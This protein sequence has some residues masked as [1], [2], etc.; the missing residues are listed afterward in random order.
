MPQLCFPHPLLIPL[1]P[2]FHA[3]HLLV[4]LLV[5]V[6]LQNIWIPTTFSL[7]W[8]KNHLVILPI[9]TLMLTATWSIY[10]SR[11]KS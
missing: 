3:N 2:N 4:T 10:Q 5:F 1:Y 8:L 6:P 11:M 9:L 7:L